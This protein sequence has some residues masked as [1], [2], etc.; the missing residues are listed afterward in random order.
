[1]K[2]V[3]RILIIDPNG[4]DVTTYQ[5]YLQQGFPEQADI[6]V[7][8]SVERGQELCRKTEFDCILTEYKLRDLNGVA[9]LQAMGYESDAS[10]PPAI[11]ITNS[12]SESIA[13]LALKQGAYDYLVKA[14]VTKEALLIAV[15][16]ALESKE[17]MRNMR[18]RQRNIQAVNFE[19]IVTGLP[20][21]IVFEKIHLLALARSQRFA[22]QY[23][24]ILINIDNLHEINKT[25]GIA[26]GDNVLSEVA[27][28]LEKTTRQADSLARSG[29]NNFVI[30]LEET[31]SDADAT[32]VATRIL[33]EMKI[34][35]KVCGKVLHIKVSIGIA[36]YPTH[37][38]SVSAVM[39]NASAAMY[40]AESE[41][42][43]CYK[44][45]SEH[46]D[47]DTTQHVT[48]ESAMPGALQRNEF[49][50]CFQPIVDMIS[51]RMVGME[52]LVRWQH[53]TRGLIS[54]DRFIPLAE[55]TGMI[56]PLGEWIIAEAC[57]QCGQWYQLGFDDIYLTINLSAC[58]L[59]YDALPT[60]VKRL[61][62]HHGIPP[63]MIK[64]E[65][66]ESAVMLN[67]R[68]S[69]GY[70]RKLHNMGCQVILDDF[71]TGY[72]SLD[73]LRYLPLTGI[74]ISSTFIKDVV[75]KVS[76]FKIVKS[77]LELGKSLEM[78]VIAEGIETLEQK[79]LIV[80]NKGRYA[81]GRLYSDPLTSQEMT[82]LLKNG[83]SIKPKPA[84]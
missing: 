38:G 58:Q 71:G 15:S 37:G 18:D 24:L 8:D 1:M 22:R 32:Q 19:D 77:V 36:N 30:L 12:G 66:T 63:G 9:F 83:L 55:K 73:L 51:E 60:L 53:S 6:T 29:G 16:S 72:S 47:R 10:L 70:L 50:L 35:F 33:S 4:V 14:E 49:F 5:S 28:R 2:K 54:P 42:G 43:D 65:L 26:V 67:P 82:T 62:E 57:I 61:I 75:N 11:M 7:C 81:Q 17:H 13:V 41:G 68:V 80:Q 64:F 59:T 25:S 44:I 34:P 79:E 56:W 31:S 3:K 45:Y 27:F 21:R 40:F 69:E 52:C 78:V 84:A 76:D 20:N 23:A 46:F 39:R 74:K 48:L